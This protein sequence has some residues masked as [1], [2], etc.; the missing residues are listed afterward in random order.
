MLC[1]DLEGWYGVGRREV[2]EGSYVYRWLIHFLVQQKHNIIKQLHS[3]L[4]KQ[5]QEEIKNDENEINTKCNKIR[6]R[7]KT[8]K[9]TF[10]SLSL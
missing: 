6:T 2:Q 10:S 3:N 7:L 4:K 1:D 5:K 8:R 9:C